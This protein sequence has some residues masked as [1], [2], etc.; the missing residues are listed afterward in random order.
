MWYKSLTKI[1][2][3]YKKRSSGTCTFDYY[4]LQEE[5]CVVCNKK[6]HHIDFNEELAKKEPN[7]YTYHGDSTFEKSEFMKF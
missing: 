3:I 7:K 2:M 5:L 6:S 1:D 4:C